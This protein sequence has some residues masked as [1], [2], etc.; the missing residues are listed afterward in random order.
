VH[1]DVISISNDRTRWT[2]TTLHK[3]AVIH[4]PMQYYRPARTYDTP[5]HERART[6]QQPPRSACMSNWRSFVSDA[7][8]LWHELWQ[9]LKIAKFVKHLNNAL[10]MPYMH[11]EFYEYIQYVK[12][13]TKSK[14]TYNVI[15]HDAKWQSMLLYNGLSYKR[16]FHRQMATS[17]KRYK[18]DTYSCNAWLTALSN[19]VTTNAPAWPRRLFQLS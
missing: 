15:D 10:F 16:I 18:I 3:H 4:W 13:L 9:A 8:A 19:G 11:D 1:C 5:T 7:H 14:V 2:P 17:Q 6:S 12:S